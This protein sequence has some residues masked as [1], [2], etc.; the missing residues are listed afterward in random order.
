MKA[1]G[2]KGAGPSLRNCIAIS[3]GAGTNGPNG[4]FPQHDAP[5]THP[6]YEVHLSITN[7]TEPTRKYN[8]TLATI[9]TES[10]KNLHNNNSM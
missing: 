4:L 1:P 8:L 7:S 9:S 5:T 2:W 10:Q 6:H 3:G